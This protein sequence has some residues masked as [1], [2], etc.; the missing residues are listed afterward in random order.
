MDKNSYYQI[1][2][3][4]IGQC[5][6]P[7]NWSDQPLVERLVHLL[8]DPKKNFFPH[9][10]VEFPLLFSRWQSLLTTESSNNSCCRLPNKSKAI[11]VPW[12]LLPTS[13]PC[14]GV[15]ANVQKNVEKKTRHS[16]HSAL[17]GS[18]E[19]CGENPLMRTK[20]FLLDRDIALIAIFAIRKQ[21]LTLSHKNVSKRDF[22]FPNSK[23]V[24]FYLFFWLDTFLCRFSTNNHKS[25]V[26]KQHFFLLCALF[27][28]Y[29][30]NDLILFFFELFPL[31]FLLWRD[32]AEIIQH[33]HTDFFCSSHQQFFR[34]FY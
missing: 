3:C 14:V 21:I 31:L 8:L 16:R 12:L 13:V 11:Y 22:I 17:I 32:F 24:F 30:F 18:P 28:H 20:N 34:Y 25:R 33:K 23:L 19:N 15:F 9:S 5:I 10:L 1:F 7:I 29:F 6:H 4:L 2:I 26:S 27:T